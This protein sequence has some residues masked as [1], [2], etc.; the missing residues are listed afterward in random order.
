[1]PAAVAAA[2]E[3]LAVGTGLAALIV[4][5]SIALRLAAVTRTLRFARAYQWALTAGTA[6]AAAY[7]VV[8]YHLAGGQALA[9]TFGAG[10]GLFVGMLAAALAEVVAALPVAGRRMGLERH[11]PRLVVAVA[12]GKTLG[13]IAWLALPGLFSRPPL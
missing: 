7:E 5:L 12:L 3:G 8:P 11:L 10:M 6:A 9:A 4:V 1:M 2:A 13:A